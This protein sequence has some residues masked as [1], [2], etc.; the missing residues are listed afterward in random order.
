MVEYVILIKA[1]FK[2]LEKEEFFFYYIISN[3]GDLDLI[4][5]V[6]PQST[7]LLQESLDILLFNYTFK[8]N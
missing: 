7:A 6:L 2:R 5:I 8:T 4:L 1:L 3:K